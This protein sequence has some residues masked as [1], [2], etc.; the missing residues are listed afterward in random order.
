MSKLRLTATHRTG[1][2]TTQPFTLFKD[3][4]PPTVTIAVPPVAPLHFRV[5]W[6]GQDGESGLRD[7]E[8]QYKVGIT[9]TWTSWL[10]DS[11]QTQA[12][13]VGEAGQSYF[14][15][16]RATDNVNNASAWVEAGPVT[17]SA[18]TKYYY[19]GDQ[20]IA[21]RQGDVVYPGR[22]PGQASSI[23]TTWDRPL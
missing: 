21:M 3:T 8:V 16:V 18:V 10:T 7:Y 23:A 1:N 15:Q 2:Q 13:F 5:S 20:R 14:F 12:P 17:V 6:S 9:G 4:I 22:Q 19:H 11:T